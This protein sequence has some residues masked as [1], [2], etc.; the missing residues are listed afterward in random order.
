MYGPPPDPRQVTV[1]AGLADLPEAWL[2]CLLIGALLTALALAR[3]PPQALRA[4]LFIGGQ[5]VI[6]TAPLAWTLERY[7]Y[8]AFPT[9][10]KEGSLL[11]YLD[12]VHERMLLHPLQ[13]AS[14]PAARL[15]GVHTG[16]L[17]VTAL[18]DLVA[19]PLGAFNLQALLYPA[20]AWW[21]AWLLLRD[22]CGSGRVALPL[23]FA[24]GM[25]LH[26]F[27]DLNWY[28]IE[29]AA[30]FWLPLFLW[31]LH[32]AWALDRSKGSRPWLWP[33]LAGLLFALMSWNNLYLGL[34][35]A[36]IGAIAAPCVLP[37]L[38]STRPAAERR[39][40]GRLLLA[41]GACAL[42]ASPLVL[43]QWALMHGPQ[44]LGD[45]ERFLWERAALDSF[46]LVP[47]RWNRL[48][49][50]RALHP[51][52]VG[53]AAYGAFTLRGDPRVRFAGLAGGLLFL[54]SLGPLLLPGVENPLYMAVRAAVPGF[55]RMA[56]PE[57]FFHGSWLLMCAVAS[58]AL[59]RLAP[60]PRSLALIHAAFV[61]LWVLLVR[62]HPVYPGLS[63]PNHDALD[64]GW[65]ERVFR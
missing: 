64:P 22:L 55:W 27:R 3:R 42:M 37:A 5:A 38:R 52:A 54:L 7:V 41:L 12:G 19:S 1:P 14:D 16:H 39:A 48:E 65:E 11:F 23:A 60:R 57:T 44:S 2:A 58:I 29:K 4:M 51:L 46:T 43:M 6:L 62:G 8:G 63:Q 17:W 61:L 31:A 59:A 40:A 15:I 26:V 45:P 28:T 20:L 30:I 47:P 13:A 34:V 35:G 18:L 10:D 49:L 9:L 21:A 50:W 33:G 56:K 25:G 36:A 24:W 53:L 32:R